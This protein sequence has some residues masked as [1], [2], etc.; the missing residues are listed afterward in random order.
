MARI[1]TRLNVMS[2]EKCCLQATLQSINVECT[3]GKTIQMYDDWLVHG[4][5]KL[6]C[7]VV[8]CEAEF[9]FGQRTLST[10]Q[11]TP[12]E[13]LFRMGLQLGELCSI[14]PLTKRIK[15]VDTEK[16]RPPS[17]ETSVKRS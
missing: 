5:V 10:H 1:R 4:F 7:N 9:F 12:Q 16:K 15:S 11:E 3:R 13:N 2:V 17:Q 14:F 8:N 6:Q